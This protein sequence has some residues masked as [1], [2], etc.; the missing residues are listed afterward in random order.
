MKQRFLSAL[1]A[2]VVITPAI[3]FLGSYATD[4]FILFILL[5]CI[6]E[7]VNMI[8]E[9]NILDLKIFAGFYGFFIFFTN[10]YFAKN[11]VSYLIIAVIFFVIYFLFRFSYE[12]LA[13]GK[14]KH[15]GKISAL[16][17]IITYLSLFLSYIPKLRS[18]PNGLLWMIML[19]TSVWLGDTGAYLVGRKIGKTPLTPISPK[20]TI[21]GSL[22]GILFSVITVFIFRFATLKTLDTVDCIT[23]GILGGLLG[24][25]GDLLES[26]IKRSFNKKD[27][28]TI[29]PGHGGAFDRFDGVIF[30]APFFYFYI[31]TFF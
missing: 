6:Y 13:E 23:L 7:T 19:M 3:L 8:F 24:Q 25:T 17:F 18:V 12:T 5:A 30:S 2:L 1:I 31:I 28:G 26:F 29:M 4:I 11:L 14:N 16:F 15:F 22:A 27:S 10:M 20:K 21:E 9:K